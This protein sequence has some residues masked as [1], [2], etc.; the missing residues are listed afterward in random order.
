MQSDNVNR[1]TLSELQR[2][3][4]NNIRR[5][6]SL[7]G[8]WVEAEMS[9]VR[10]SGGHCYME[11]LEKNEGGY[12]VAKLRAIIWNGVYQRLNALFLSATGKKICTGLKVLV[13]G[14]VTYHEIYGISFVINNIDPSY[15]LGDI[16]R[17]RREILDR[18]HREGVALQ[19]KSIELGIA[20]QRIAVISSAG[21]AGYGDF[22]D[23]L[24]NNSDGFKIYS[25]LFP[26]TLQGDRT[27]PTVLYALDIVEQ[28]IEIAGWDC[29]VI[30][31]GG[32]ATTDL[33]SFDNYELARRVSTFPIPV[34]VGIGHERDRNVLDELANVSCKTPTAVAEFL[35]HRLQESYGRVDEMCKRI[36][37]YVTLRMNGEH[38]RLNNA[39][40]SLPGLVKTQ[41]IRA[42]INLERLKNRIENTSR[43]RTQIEVRNLDR[44][45]GRIKTSVLI[46]LNDAKSKLERME[47]MQ[48]VLSPENTLKRGYSITRVNG[49]AVKDSSQVRPGDRLES[50]LAHGVI[51]S[52]VE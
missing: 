33:N 9:D 45:V 34:I 51:I 19:N 44:I 27:V 39:E 3:V 15:T 47:G 42:G 30:I 11:L 4:G 21:A 29:V 50:T 18:L 20:P 16:E 25:M 32:G 49:H 24:V 12:T 52:K 6:P 7:Q 36:V 5:D 38:L 17:I 41:T 2:V 48:R 26:A 14:T 35:I 37:R 1:L 43:G 10:L 28:S 22:M 31:R 46:R 8:V 23:Q 13:C 40:V